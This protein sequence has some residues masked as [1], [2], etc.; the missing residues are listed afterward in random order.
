[1]TKQEK[2]YYETK[3]TEKEFLTWYQEKDQPTYE[4][5]SVTIDNVIFSYDRQEDLLKILLI[6]RKNHPFQDYWALPGGFIQKGESADDCCI[7]ETYEETGI[8]IFADQI[9]QL[10]TF[11]EPER[12]PRGWILT[13]SYLAFLHQLP[14]QAGSDAGEARWFDIWIDS[15]EISLVSGDD[16]LILT[17]QKLAFDH[18]KIIQMAIKRIVGKLYYQPKLLLLLEPPF[19]IVEARKVFGKFLGVPYKEIDHSNFKKEILK[20]V[21]EVG[22]RPTGVGRPSKY[23]QLKK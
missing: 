15:N 10:Y 19:T 6:K 7:R 12:D 2:K 5:P 20:F 23:Y 3:A 9:E 16:T 11:T 22:E 13:I 18:V 8:K 4:T 1:M 14:V 17:D 21:D